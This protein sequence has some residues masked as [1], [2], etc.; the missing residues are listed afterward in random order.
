MKTASEIFRELVIHE[1]G[2][3][4]I[5]YALLGALIVV[6]IVGSVALVGAKTFSMWNMVA[7][8]VSKATTGAGSCP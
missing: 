4:A 5:E 8:C 1:D 3:T 7:N 6:V 2:I